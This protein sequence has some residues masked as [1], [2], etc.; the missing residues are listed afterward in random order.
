MKVLFLQN[1]IMHYRAPLYNEMSK[2]CKL[3]VGHSGRPLLIKNNFQEVI[4]KHKKFLGFTWQFG[5][6]SL[7]KKFDVIILMFDIRWILS[8]IVVSLIDLFSIFKINFLNN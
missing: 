4:L 3:T 2:F 6:N 7:S 8:M 1:V 5:V